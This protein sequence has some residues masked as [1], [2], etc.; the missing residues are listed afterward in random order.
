MLKPPWRFGAGTPQRIV[1]L[2]LKCPGRF[3][4][5]T[6]GGLGPVKP[7]HRSGLCPVK[8]G[9]VVIQVLFPEGIRGNDNG[10]RGGESRWLHQAYSAQRD[11]PN[12]SRQGGMA[13]F[14]R[15]KPSSAIRFVR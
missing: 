7:R 1:P 15:Q 3:G 10:G 11:L 13:R 5:G 14:A 8:L 2:V 4:I 12:G 9:L 6:L